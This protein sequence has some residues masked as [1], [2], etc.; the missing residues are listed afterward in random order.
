MVKNEI[1]RGD[2]KLSK[3]ILCYHVYVPRAIDWEFIGRSRN[4]YVFIE[5]LQRGQ[6]NENALV[7]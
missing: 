7:M 2:G 4:F 6:F 3:K 5:W 1:G